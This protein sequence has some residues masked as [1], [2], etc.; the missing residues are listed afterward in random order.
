MSATPTV[1]ISGTVRE[2]ALAHPSAIRI[3]EQFAIDYCCG[4]H[5]PLAEACTQAG[6]DLTAVQSALAGLSAK[7]P[8]EAGEAATIAALVDRIV[9]VHHGFVRRETPR[10]RALMDKVIA[11]HGAT[12]PELA[13][14][15]FHFDALSQE[16]SSHMMRE[17]QVLFPF[18]VQMEEAAAHGHALPQTFFATVRQPIGAM[19]REHDEAAQHAA[20]IRRLSSNYHAPDGACPSFHGLYAGLHDYEADLHRHVHLENNLLFPRA[21]ALERSLKSNEAEWPRA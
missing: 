19:M 13:G 16:L 8:E 7:A 2:I 18:C 11:R 6:A 5:R 20:T 12:S 4:G 10:L 17:E 1:S 15:Q 9:T 3:F 21:E 14:I